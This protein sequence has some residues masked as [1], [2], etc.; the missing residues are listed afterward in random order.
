MAK[1]SLMFRA[2]RRV[3]RSELVCEKEDWRSLGNSNPCFR[4]ER[5]MYAY[6]ASSPKFENQHKWPISNIGEPGQTWM[7]SAIFDHL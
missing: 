1:R 4:R 3:M 7:L 6:A 2:P 5:G